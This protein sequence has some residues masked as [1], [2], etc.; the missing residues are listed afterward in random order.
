MV[1][2]V[3]R[4][5][6]VVGIRRAGEHVVEH[7]HAE[8]VERRAVVLDDLLLDRT[9]LDGPRRLVQQQ[10]RRARRLEVQRDVEYCDGIVKKYCVISFCVSASRLPPVIAGISPICVS[11]TVLDPRNIMCSVACASP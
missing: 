10:T 6:S 4:P 2:P 5:E 3:E 9:A 11:S 7:L 8:P 1:E